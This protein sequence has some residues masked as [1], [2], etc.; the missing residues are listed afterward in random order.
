[1][2][3]FDKQCMDLGSDFLGRTCDDDLDKLDT[4]ITNVNELVTNDPNN[5]TVLA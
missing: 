5:D 1:M 3:S 2:T 4:L